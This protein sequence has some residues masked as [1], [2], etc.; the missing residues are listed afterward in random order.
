MSLL[1]AAAAAASKPA[2]QGASLLATELNKQQD[3]ILEGLGQYVCQR[4]PLPHHFT[5]MFGE[6]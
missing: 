1:A 4:V 2:N 5:V 6:L 3:V